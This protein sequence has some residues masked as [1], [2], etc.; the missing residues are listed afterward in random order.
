MRGTDQLKDGVT[1]KVKVDQ[2]LNLDKTID[3]ENVQIENL[4][5]VQTIKLLPTYN[6]HNEVANQISDEYIE[7]IDVL[8]LDLLSVFHEEVVELL[9]RLG[10]AL[11]Q[12]AFVVVWWL[13]QISNSGFG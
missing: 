11:R 4:K 10:G 5:N 13:A 3:R 1:E 9:P 8:D 2:N 7:S 12:C 6:L